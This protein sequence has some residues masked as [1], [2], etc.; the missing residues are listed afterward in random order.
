MKNANR[1]TA[2]VLLCLCIYFFIESGNFTSFGLLFPR[3]IV[4]ILAFLSLMLLILSFVKP[5]EGKVFDTLNIRYLPV[6]I[7]VSLMIAWAFIIDLIG[8]YITSIVF[9]PLIVVFLDRKS[10]PIVLI[11]NIGI[12]IAIVTGFYFFF[13]KVLQVPFPTGVL[14]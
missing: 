3:V 11:R 5:E 4:G 2:A 6:I 7:S 1:I 14:F 8:F 13:V 9:F 12:V 10:K